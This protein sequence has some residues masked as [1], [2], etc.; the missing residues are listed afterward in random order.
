MKYF[1]LILSALLL[2]LFVTCKKSK[3]PAENPVIQEEPKEYLSVEESDRLATLPSSEPDDSNT[4]MP[5]GVSVKTY[6]QF[7]KDF[8]PSTNWRANHNYY[9][10]MS[11][12]AALQYFFARMSSRSN[13]LT[14]RAN[15]QKK[16]EGQDRPA[17]NGL[18]YVYGSDYVDNRVQGVASNCKQYLYGLDCSGFINQLLY[19]AGLNDFPDYSANDQRKVSN[20]KYIYT[21]NELSKISITD[22]GAIKAQDVQFGDIIYWKNSNGDAFHIG[23][24][25]NENGSSGLSVSNGSPSNSCSANTNSKRGPMF[26][27]GITQSHL[28]LINSNYSIVRFSSSGN[29][30]SQMKFEGGPW[31]PSG[32]PPSQSHRT[33]WFYFSGGGSKFYYSVNN[34]SFVQSNPKKD[35]SG[36][37]LFTCEVY[38]YQSGLNKFNIVLMDDLGNTLTKKYE[39]TF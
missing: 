36:N 11:E 35:A 34:S 38:K 33:A 6:L 22:M 23:F 3:A 39:E 24:I 29:G 5:S 32:L 10:G 26:F 15:F 19:N 27:N 9:S 20:L 2:T 4:I 30:G 14:K 13:Y 31:G 25:S 17:Q 21:F 7:V 12:S 28:E 37:Y 8:Y 18:A 1:I 16:D